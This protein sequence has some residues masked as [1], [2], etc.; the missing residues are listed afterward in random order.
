MG[1][2][3]PVVSVVGITGVTLRLGFL[4]EVLTGL[5]SFNLSGMG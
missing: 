4:G 5:G 1:K 2:V 3:I